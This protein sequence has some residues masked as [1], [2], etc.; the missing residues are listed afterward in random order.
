MRVTI[1]TYLERED[2]RSYDA[3]VDQV[4]EALAN[5]GHKVS[6]LGVHKSVKKLVAGI[7]R[8]KPDL[9]F[10]LMEMFN[11]KLAGDIGVAGLLDLVGIPYTGG[12]PGEAYLCHDK[13]LTKKL[14]AFDEIPY[15]DFAV[16]ELDTCIE[17][18]GNLRMPLFVKPLRSDASLGI[19]G[20]SVVRNS[21][22]LMKRV[23]AIHQ[24]M[25]DSALAEEY[26]EGREFYVG[27]L[28]NRQPVAFPPIEVDFSRMPKGKPHVVDAK[29]K[30]EKESPEFKGTKPVIPDLPEELR[31]KLEQV[32]LKAYQALRVLDYGRVD[33]RM[34]EAGEIYVI[35]VN[36]SCYL[37]RSSEFA[38]AAAASGFDYPT[39]ID[40]IAQL[41][42]ERRP[43]H[44]K[45][46]KPSP[47]G[48]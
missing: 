38:T 32:S 1:L 9:I 45:L 28:G 5:R 10:N 48:V 3:V 16:F 39:L 35:E 42:L 44:V 11:D 25:K 47:V 8:R 37:E 24:E 22:E 33:L 14:L 15:P 12:G 13:A 23:V 6:V 46:S 43:Q 20:K 41:A 2:S 17:I 31:G 21:S 4:A 19:N 27:V 36:A 29:A 34:N 30:W 40:R 7:Y 18:A 26:I